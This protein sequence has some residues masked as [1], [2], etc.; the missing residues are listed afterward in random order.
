VTLVVGVT[1]G[2]GSGK[3]AVTD[4]LASLGVTIVDADLAARV[5]V[6][7]GR[8]ALDAIADRFGEGI[9]QADG[10]LDRAA[11]RGIV[12]AEPEQRAWLE[13]LTHPL[14]GEEIQQQLARSTSPYTVLSSPLLL[15]TNQR[16]LCDL[17]VVV[18]VPESVQL[19]RTMARDNNDEVQV[20]R[21]MSAQSSRAERL[22]AADEVIS[23]DAS[24]EVL[25][26]RVER[27]HKSLL[28]RAQA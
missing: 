9:L 13:Q 21:I 2:I 17:V 18:D 16:D 19:S 6:E 22:A 5:V 8:P 20:R 10:T 3:S 1:G 23:N 15:E 24:L 7:P 11:L 14:I 12:F 25:H 26:A 28:K 4:H 27:L